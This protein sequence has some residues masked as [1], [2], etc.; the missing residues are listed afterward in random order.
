MVLLCGCGRAAE[1]PPPV[2]KAKAKPKPTAILFGTIDEDAAAIY[3]SLR[4]KM[5]PLPNEV[6]GYRPPDVAARPA[7]DRTL[8]EYEAELAALARAARAKRCAWNPGR[9][10]YFAPKMDAGFSIKGARLLRT[11]FLRRMEEGRKDEAAEALVV[12]LKAATDYMADP[13]L[14]A[15][16][17]GCV[18]I[19]VMTDA[20][21]AGVAIESFDRAE[22][23]YLERH[24]AILAGRVPSA[25]K[26]LLDEQACIEA[27]IDPF[28]ENGFE[29]SVGLMGGN[30][31]PDS[32]TWE[33]LD[34]ILAHD[35]AA[36]RE[37]I[38]RNC[39]ETIAMMVEDARG[40]LNS[41]EVRYNRDKLSE[42]TTRDL[43]RWK[44]TQGDDPSKGLK[45]ASVMVGFLLAPPSPLKIREN[46]ALARLQI[47]A[48]RLW[49]R[50]QRHGL[51]KGAYP[52][53][54]QAVPDVP[55]D[56]FDGGAIKYVRRP[57]GDM[58]VF[59]LTAAGP[60]ED[61][62]DR[63]QELAMRF[64]YDVHQLKFLEGQ[65]GDVFLYTWVGRMTRRP[66]K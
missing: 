52:E 13:R 59:V 21:Q 20:F 3:E 33:Y 37:A 35:R 47:D 54:L 66:G 9:L 28:L 51:E 50:L 43:A 57:W 36:S 30:P 58:S 44:V 40:L 8:K 24:L 16:L 5:G 1:P 48:L 56:P 39:K 65:E 18:V 45:P 42:Q 32:E 2:S 11:L 46:L 29:K 27:S 22:L 61:W 19:A 12:G 34:K 38:S 60:A 63:V 15:K 31:T 55:R 64:L 10:D 49:A 6:V 53:T 14:I 7:V 17:I 41:K 23:E 26:A 4:A 25:E 62:A